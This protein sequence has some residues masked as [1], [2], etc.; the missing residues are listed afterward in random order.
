MQ[1]TPSLCGI[2]ASALRVM[3]LSVVG[4]ALLGAG[5]VMAAREQGYS[6]SFFEPD[7]EPPATE[8]IDPRVPPELRDWNAPD[9]PVRVGLQVGHWKVAEVPE[10]LENLKRNTGAR[11][12]GK[13]EWEVAHAI[14]EETRALLAPYGVVVDLLP[15]TVPQDYVA[16]AVVAIHADGNPDPSVTGYKLAAPRRDLSG[17]AALLA[18]YLDR[19]YARGTGMRLDPNV[20]PNMRGYYAFNWRRYDHALHPMTPAVILETGFLTSP[21]DRRILVQDPAI[22]ARGIAEALVG[23]LGLDVFAPA[24]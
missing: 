24:M 14:A 10:E 13:D 23:F 6:W 17:R 2:L 5:A 8:T 15:A 20:T 4:T 1:Y 16:D 3:L 11:G 22:A 7:F 21:A 19:A 12:G 9:G 18:W